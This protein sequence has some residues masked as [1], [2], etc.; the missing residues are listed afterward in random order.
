[1]LRF[2]SYRNGTS[3]NFVE[4]LATGIAR[5]GFGDLMKRIALTCFVGFALIVAAA[6]ETKLRAK[7]QRLESQAPVVLPV[8]DR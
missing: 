5:I 3:K 4:P 1:M 8:S 7:A 6:M 2:R